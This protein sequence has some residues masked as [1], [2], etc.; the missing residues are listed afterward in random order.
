M[1]E[2][3]FTYREIDARLELYKDSGLIRYYSDNEFL[4]LDIVDHYKQWKKQAKKTIAYLLKFPITLS[5]RELREMGATSELYRIYDEHNNRK[6]VKE[7]R[8]RIEAVSLKRKIM[9]GISSEINNFLVNNIDPKQGYYLLTV[10]TYKSN[11]SWSLFRFGEERKIRQSYAYRLLSMNDEAHIKSI[12]A[13]YKNPDTSSPGPSIRFNILKR[14]N[15][16]CQ[17]CGRTSQEDGVKLEIDHKIPK[18]KGGLDTLDNLW[19]L[20]FT[21]NSGKSD[22]DL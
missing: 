6:K 11:L 20:C 4:G 1:N 17:I 18:S 22:K 21:C 3:H 15:Y 9:C 14:D 2:E 12:I 8:R 5:D 13:K 19:T 16:A 7:I 10:L